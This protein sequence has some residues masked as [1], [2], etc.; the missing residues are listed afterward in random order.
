MRIRKATSKDAEEIAEIEFRSRYRWRENRKNE[1]KSA[2]KLLKSKSQVYI[3]ELNKKIVGYIALNIKSNSIE[4]LAVNKKYHGKGIG[5]KLMNYVIKA[6]AKKINRIRI[7]VWGKNYAAINLYN[8]F[9]FNVVKIKK[10][11][12]PNKDAKLIMEKKL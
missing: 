12:Y 7:S 11:F 6:A 8:K 1:L 4:F 3:A 2:E 10:N 9:G 5:T